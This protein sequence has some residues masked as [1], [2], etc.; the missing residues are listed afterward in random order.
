[1][2]PSFP[3]SDEGKSVLKE[4]IKFEFNQVLKEL[5]IAGEIQEVFIQDII[6]L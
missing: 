1:V 6:A 2:I 3:L 4:K 5:N